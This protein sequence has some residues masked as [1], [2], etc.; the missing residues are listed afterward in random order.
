M[1]CYAQNLEQC[2]PCLPSLIQIHIISNGRFSFIRDFFQALKSLSR[3]RELGPPDL[4]FS[5]YFSFY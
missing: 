2:L 3:K 1:C 5:S 4:E